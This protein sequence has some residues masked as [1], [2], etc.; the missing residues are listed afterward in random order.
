[1]GPFQARALTSGMSCAVV[2]LALLVP[3]PNCL[4]DPLRV[5]TWNLE[6]PTAAGTNEVPLQEAAA[7]LKQLNPDVI[8]LQQ[9]R[10][11][12]ECAQ[13][14]QALKPA[15]YSVPVCSAFRDARTGT[16]SKQQVGI[17]SKP[18]AYFAWSEAWRPQGEAPVPGGFA[19]A[20]IKVGNQRIGFYSVQA[21]DVA[22]DAR[23]PGQRAAVA[24]AEAASVGQLLDHVGSVSNWV[25]N[26]VQ[27]FV[28][29]ATFDTHAAVWTDARDNILRLLET[30]GFGDA[31]F[32]TS[33]AARITV[34]G[35]ARSPGATAD[36]VLTDPAGCAAIPRVLPSTISAHS[37]V[38]CEVELDPAIIAAARAS[39]AEAMRAREVLSATPVQLA[40]PVH[41]PST[42]NY[43]LLWVAALAG[44]VALVAFAGIL[45][46]RARRPVPRP[47]ALLTAGE[48]M[49]SSYTVVVG[50][51]SAT[52]VASARAPALPTAEPII[53]IEAPGTTQ[54]QAEALRRRT[55]VAEERAERANA[56]IRAGLIPHLRQ[57]LKQK[58]V[59]KLIAD[60]AQM[61]E[62][63]QAA[64][65]KALAVEE[66]LERI[67][68]QFQRQNASYQT[69]IQE[70]TRELIVAK[71]EN[72]ELIRARI[73]QVKA[74]ME[75]ARARLMA[76]SDPDG[77]S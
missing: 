16:L 31:F 4:A 45:A 66:R 32:E 23:S 13:L 55:L 20:A 42:I 63:Q 17:L 70:L 36:Y 77:E 39:R 29:A 73:A 74:E 30:G 33:A 10:D 56:V 27:I 53:H 76:G 38:I 41:Q 51:R 43:Q 8:L 62:T 24:H 7:V 46:R 64:T 44:L 40:A 61:L 5:L 50:T 6:P 15:E 65:H 49:P 68:Q 3:L 28:V 54:T 59:R 25:A 52:D 60:R 67:E 26:R 18:K 12:K 57:W 75:A 47:P 14:A 37:P 9:V 48:D 1:M 2:G 35:T 72:R 71:E 69:R 21:G 34:A 22:M 11:W 58:L 19:F